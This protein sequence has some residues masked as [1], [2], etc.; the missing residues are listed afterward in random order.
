[1]IVQEEKASP[2]LPQFRVTLN[3]R[4]GRACFFCRPSGEAVATHANQELTVDEL[5]TV[6]KSVRRF[7]IRDIKL[8]GGDPA[9]Y[10][11]LEEAVYRLRSDAGFEEI[12]LIS[13][14]PLIGPRAKR[15][16]EAGVTKFN[17]S[18][19]TLD[20]RLHHELCGDN[21]LPGV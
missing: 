13:R 7:G 14:H 5:V 12:E 3:S 8:T 16:A 6:A 9:L 19:D 21:D 15:L 2:N 1:M 4:C 18:V 11:P 10:K 17:I 20:P